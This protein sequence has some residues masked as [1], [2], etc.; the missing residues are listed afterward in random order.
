MGRRSDGGFW[1]APGTPQE[2]LFW[3]ELTQQLVP[4]ALRCVL[5]LFHSPNNLVWSLESLGKSCLQRKRSGKG[6]P[7]ERRNPGEEELALWTWDLCLLAWDGGSSGLQ[8]FRLQVGWSAGSQDALDLLS[9]L[10]ITPTGE[11]R[12]GRRQIF[13]CLYALQQEAL[14]IISSL[15]P[16]SRGLQG[17]HISSLQEGSWTAHSI[18]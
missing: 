8:T 4:A 5:S 1:D 12:H 7:P 11:L 14:F 9:K 3:G 15:K 17:V 10:Y 16:Y 18:S 13:S 2:A 6:S